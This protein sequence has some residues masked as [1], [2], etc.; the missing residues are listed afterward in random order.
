MPSGALALFETVAAGVAS[1][2]RH[3][4][5]HGRIRPENVLFDEEDNAYV[6]DLGVDEICAGVITF[7]TTAYDAPERLGGVLATP[8]A[9][10]YSLGVLAHHL[11][12]G[13]PP[14][15]DGPLPLGDGPVAGVLGRAT[16]P[17]PGRRHGSVDELMAELRDALAVP[18]DPTAVFVAHPQPVP[19]PRAVRAG[20]RRGLLRSGPRR[21][22]DGRGARAGA[23]A[24]RRRA[25]GDRQV[26]GGEGRARA[27][28][29]PGCAVGGS[30]SWL[31][32]EMVPGRDPFEQLA[33]ALE[34]VAN[35]ALPDVV[36]ELTSSPGALDEVVRQLVPPRHRAARRDR[37]ARGAVH[38]DGRRG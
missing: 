20:R 7:A 37:P 10:V 36:G 3:G 18:A 6:A 17:D 24:R 13:S 31:V 27:C 5:V 38:P 11:L 21:R 16:D 8:A 23:A 4:V 26:V 33:A 14:P 12:G 35:V 25:V 1:A 32:T 19:R 9:D 15:P 2:H 29:R 34:R 22:G 30:E 28:A